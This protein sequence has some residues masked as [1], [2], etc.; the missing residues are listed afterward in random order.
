MTKPLFLIALLV[1]LYRRVLYLWESQRPGAALLTAIGLV[2]VGSFSLIELSALIG[3]SI[4][5]VTRMG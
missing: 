2:A 4:A 5:E 1:L 3:R